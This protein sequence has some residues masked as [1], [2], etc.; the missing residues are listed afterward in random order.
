MIY[1]QLHIS[2]YQTGAKSAFIS[3]DWFSHWALN[4]E[5]WL[6]ITLFVL[7]SLQIKQNAS[8][9]RLQ[10][11]PQ[12]RPVT[13]SPDLLWR[14]PLRQTRVILGPYSQIHFSKIL[15]CLR[16]LSGAV[17]MKHTG[18]RVLQRKGVN[19]LSIIYW[20]CSTLCANVWW[21]E[22]SFFKDKETLTKIWYTTCQ[23]GWR[24]SIT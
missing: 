24:V 4:Q 23:S 19:H 1:I 6:V 11:K 10:P 12:R 14:E 22:N 13:I 3:T 15:K 5:L 2:L 18:C 17:E 21:L 7:T 9:C 16:F 20:L 8:Q